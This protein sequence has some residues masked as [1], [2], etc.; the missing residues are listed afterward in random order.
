MSLLADEALKGIDLRAADRHRCIRDRFDAN[1]QGCWARPIA[2]LAALA[3]VNMTKRV[4]S[5][6]KLRR[7]E[8]TCCA[9]RIRMTSASVSIG[10]STGSS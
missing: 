3:L 4:T 8:A 9:R 10:S 2:G 6:S 7:S 1:G 5:I